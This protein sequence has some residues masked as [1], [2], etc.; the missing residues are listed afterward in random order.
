M[1]VTM[2]P[3]PRDLVAT[4]VARRR[5][6]A[7]EQGERGTR[8]HDR[9]RRIAQRLRQERRLDGAWLVGSLAWGGFGERSDVDLVVRGADETQLGALWI[10]VGDA[11]DAEVD[12]LRLEDLPEAFAARVLSEGERLDEP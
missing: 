8:L 1:L 12:L 5:A 3:G 2:D 11:L 9:A 10:L 4:L 6:T 7:L